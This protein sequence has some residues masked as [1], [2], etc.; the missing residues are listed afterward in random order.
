[1]T[2]Q[3]AME[4]A[5]EQFTQ[6]DTR[7][8][9]AGRTDAGVHAL[10]QVAHVD[11]QK[12]W[13]PEKIIEA[14]NGILQTGGHR[15]G[16]LSAERVT[17]DFDAR[18]SA[19]KRH[20]RYRLIN[21]ITPL[22]VENERAWWVRFP[23]NVEAMNDAAQALLGKHDFSTF[24]S[25]DCQAKSP[26]RTLDR[27]DVSVASS[28]GS[29]RGEGIVINFDVTARAFL[30]NQVRSMVGSLKMIGDGK[31]TKDDLLTALKA[32]DRK[33]CGVVS[34]SYGLYLTRVDYD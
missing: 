31:W 5:F 34:P 16:I 19:T 27:L 2:V 23:L 28:N 12:A 15:I 3:Q 30:H 4:E 18:F 21:R 24:R 17:E 8:F 13:K 22:T 7:V 14:A 33:A 29:I 25:T 9:A 26:I 1:M 20:Y 32:R 10:G 11:L 6:H